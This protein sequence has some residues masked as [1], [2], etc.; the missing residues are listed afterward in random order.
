[1]APNDTHTGNT[2]R[3]RQIGAQPACGIDTRC[4][5]GRFAVG[6]RTQHTGPTPQEC[7]AAL[8]IL[9]RNMICASHCQQRPTDR[10]RSVDTSTRTGRTGYAIPSQQTPCA[11]TTFACI[12]PPHTRNKAP[13]PAVWIVSK[14][15]S[16]TP[17]GVGMIALTS[18]GPSEE[19][20]SSISLGV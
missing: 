6:V 10:N 18:S 4:P 2:C 9:F 12:N 20:R 19:R 7:K 8:D 11:A 15:P 3:A 17:P 16:Q 5:S 1:M 14:P 13:D